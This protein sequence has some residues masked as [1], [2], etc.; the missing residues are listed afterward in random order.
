MNMDYIS[1]IKSDPL[2]SS[3]VK[4]RLRF[5]GE[6]GHGE[7]KLYLTKEYSPKYYVDF[8]E[9]YNDSNLYL[10]TQDNLIN[11]LNSDIVQSEYTTNSSSYKNINNNYRLN[12]IRSINTNYEPKIY[13]NFEKR[14]SI[15]SQDRYYIRSSDQVFKETFRSISIPKITYLEIEKYK[16]ID[17]NDNIEK[18]AFVCSLNIF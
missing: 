13:F 3:F 9:N 10:F 7:A 4:K 5:Q 18:Y 14:L 2:P 17:D 11:Y 12:M 1:S 16:Y 8:F 6:T 15:D